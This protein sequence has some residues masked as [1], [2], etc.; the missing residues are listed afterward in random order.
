MFA[1]MKSVELAKK[2]LAANSYQIV[3]EGDR[4]IAFRYRLNT[5]YFWGYADDDNFFVLMLPRFDDVTDDNIRHIK[6][7][8]MNV[9]AEI[10]QIKLYL[11]YDTLMATAE[12]YYLD[13]SDFTYQ[14]DRALKNLVE[15][16][17]MYHKME[18]SK[19]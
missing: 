10:K 5:I 15:A 7:L 12:L 16:K 2:Y 1:N 13:S 18:N 17:V 14:F 11:T 19:M 9:N 3:D 8:C 6:E 4:Y